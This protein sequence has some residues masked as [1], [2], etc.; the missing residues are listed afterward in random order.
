MMAIEQLPEWQIA[1]LDEYVRVANEADAQAR[2]LLCFLDKADIRELSRHLKTKPLLNP[3]SV[4][5][6]ADLIESRTHRKSGAAGADK[7]HG[8]RNR[9]RKLAAMDW[10]MTV[11]DKMK[12]GPAATEIAKRFNVSPRTARDWLK[13]A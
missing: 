8:Q 4:V 5:Y 10:F 1:A 12:K 2:E 6:L 9:P 7:L 11:R 3:Y 13:G